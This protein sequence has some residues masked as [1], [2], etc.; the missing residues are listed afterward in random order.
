MLCTFNTVSSKMLAS[1][2]AY[3]GKSFKYLAIF[4][5]SL[6]KYVNSQRSDNGVLTVDYLVDILTPGAIEDVPTNIISSKLS[7]S[8]LA[9]ILQKAKDRVIT[10]INILH[11]NYWRELSGVVAEKKRWDAI[12]LLTEF[13]I[14]GDRTAK[15]IYGLLIE[16]YVYLTILRTAEDG[17]DMSIQ[18]DL[19]LE[20]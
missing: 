2:D 18:Y 13:L 14:R 20:Y 7:E 12:T 6:R 1:A 15:I 4:D 16:L 5:K 19:S 8:V 11:A 3:V 10:L 9:A 17:A